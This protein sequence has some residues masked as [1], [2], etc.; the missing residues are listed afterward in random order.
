MDSIQSEEFICSLCKYGVTSDDYV[1]RPCSDQH[2]THILCGINLKSHHYRN[3]WKSTCPVCG[4]VDKEE[5]LEHGNFDIY[6]NERKRTR[7][8]DDEIFKRYTFYVKCLVNGA[9]TLLWLM[10]VHSLF[11]IILHILY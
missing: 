7:E 9:Y 3:G 5:P 1:E 2:R 8:K 11:F 10:I 6:E 4:V